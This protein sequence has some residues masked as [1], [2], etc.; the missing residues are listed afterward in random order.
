MNRVG[1]KRL[2]RNDRRYECKTDLG[3]TERKAV[4]EGKHKIVLRKYFVA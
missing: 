2:A 3:I 4:W 1:E